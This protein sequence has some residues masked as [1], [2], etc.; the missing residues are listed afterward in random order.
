[1]LTVVLQPHHVH[2][3]DEADP[4]VREAFLQ[5]LGRCERFHSGYI[6]RGCHD[7][8]GSAVLIAAGPV[9]DADA[10]G[11]MLDRFIHGQVLRSWLL[12]GDHHV[13]ILAGPQAMISG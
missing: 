13:H 1:M 8:V 12:P 2:D 9:P 3:I 6:T 7:Q 11:A 4:Q 10:L 5:N